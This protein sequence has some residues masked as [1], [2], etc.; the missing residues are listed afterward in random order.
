MNTGMDNGFY[1][2]WRNIHV[3]LLA[4]TL[5]LAQMGY[6]QSVQHFQHINVQ[7]GLSQ[8][9][10]NYI[11][12]DHHGFIWFSTGDG[13]NRYDGKDFITYKSGFDK[14]HTGRLPDRNINSIVY[15]DHKNRLWFTS[16]AGLSCLDKRTGRSKVVL[17]SHTTRSS[18]ILMALDST[19]VWIAVPREGIF[20]VSLDDLKYEQYRFT[21]KMQAAVAEFLPVYNGVATS[22]GIWICDNIGLIFFDKKTH[23]DTRILLK[24]NVNSVHLMKNGRLLLCS[25]NGVYIYD[26]PTGKNNFIPLA[27]RSGKNVIQWKTFAE[28]TVGQKIYLS[29][30]NDPRICKLDIASGEYEFLNF[31]NTKVNNIYID[32]SQNLWV[33]TDGSGVYKL[34]IKPPK[35]SFYGPEIFYDEAQ[36]KSFMVKSIFKDNYGKIWM[37]VYNTG[38]VIYDPETR[39]Q[40]I[41]PLSIPPGELLISNIC[42]DSAGHIVTSVDD[43]IF[44]LDEKSHRVLYKAHMLSL[45]QTSSLKPTIYALA[46]WKY[47][48]YLIGT[49]LG[50]FSVT[51]NNNKIKV[52][53]PANFRTDS[54]ISGWPYNFYKADDGLLYLGLRSGF[55]SLRMISDSQ[56]SL[57]NFDFRGLPIRHF[58][59][60]IRYNILWIASEHGLIAYNEKTKHYK[61]FDEQTGLANS[62]IYA[63]LDESD[64][65]LWISTNNGISNLHIRYGT[66]TNITAHITN[67][68]IKDGL[69]SSEF[70]TGAFFKDS[71]GTLFFG[72]IAGINWFHPQKITSNNFKARPAVSG[73]YINDKLYAGDTAIFIE[74]L[75]VP[76]KDNTLSFSFSALEYTRPGH[77]IFAYKLQGLDK[78]WVYTG[79]DRVRYSNLPP[80]KYTFLLK[81]S[82]NDGIWNNKPLELHITVLPPWWQTWWFRS[83][84]AICSCLFIYLIIRYYI[85]QKILAK[86][87]E[88]E[89]QQALYM[90][91]LRISKDVHDD[92]GS[93][94]SKISLMAEIAQN[95]ATGNRMPG[96]EI[97]LISAVSRELVENM[98]DLIWVL[99]PDNTTLEQLVSR[100]REYC[101]DYLESMPFILSLDFPTNVP[102]VAIARE[103]QRNIFL[104]VKEAINNCVKHAAAKEIKIQLSL[105]NEQLL[106][107]VSDNGKGFN[108]ADLRGSGNGLRN[109]KQRIDIIGG[110]F[111]VSSIPGN[112]TITI[113]IPLDTL[114]GKNTTFV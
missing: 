4:L 9:T 34:D 86:T 76:Y 43:Y 14:A 41:V 77:N 53:I 108:I 106:I 104:T 36:Q 50:L 74:H 65:S 111:T 95:N 83:L 13:L 6:A 60:N 31:Q 15:E 75:R 49:N 98:R 2:Q 105:S 81:A 22:G 48:H 39:K 87:R 12:Q 32:R 21:E 52:S 107:S 78:E 68:T 102:R 100:L 63:I 37:G 29:A 62:F 66:D 38:L 10:V 92:L 18:A 16:D 90:E 114:T 58:Y 88:L 97:K 84:V 45:Y 112:T 55:T 33:G 91:R 82:N 54:F 67:Y 30:V 73:I 42:R 89:K 69:Q 11:F 44:W 85:N 8:S 94:L 70:N 28:D 35:F 40:E 103:A 46:E 110:T 72:G 3:W 71:D 17:N 93:G 7:D 25:G 5:L 101:T 47:G 23:K 99:N 27:D 26:I 1:R 51:N 113:T 19:Y 59:K 56:Y 20:R 79:N 24:E 64:T 80:G 61:V 57:H 109:M 96:N